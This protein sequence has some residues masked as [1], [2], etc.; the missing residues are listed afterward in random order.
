MNE[1]AAPAS[2][3]A[4]RRVSL[5]ILAQLALWTVW[6]G[7][8]LARRGHFMYDEAYGYHRAVRVAQEHWLPVTGWPW[9]GGAVAYNPGGFFDLAVAVPFLFGSDPALATWWL[10]LLSALAIGVLDLALRRGAAPPALRLAVATGLCWSY[11]HARGV[12][13]L[14][15]PNLMWTWS[16]VGL[17]L[18]LRI[19]QAGPTRLRALGLGLWMAVGLQC[20]PGAVMAIAVIGL[21]L[22]RR[23]DLRA[24]GP[25]ALVAAGFTLPFVPYLVLEAGQGF[26]NTARLLAVHSPTR[27]AWVVVVKA[28]LAPLLSVSQLAGFGTS[29]GGVWASLSGQPDRWL[30][31]AGGGLLLGYGLLQPGPLR[32]PLLAAMA[33]IP[34]LFLLT[35]R[36]YEEHFVAALVPYFVVMAAIG[37]AALWRR[38]GRARRALAAYAL[39]FVGVGVFR[40]AWEYEHRRDPT[41]PSETRRVAQWVEA[42]AGVVP[43]PADSRARHD[44]FVLWSL[45]QHLAG[46]TPVFAL[47]DREGVCRVAIS[48]DPPPSARGIAN[49]SFFLC[50]PR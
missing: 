1:P 25:A 35:R 40:T 20:H 38:G 2:D 27:F 29:T 3:A 6:A 31:L 4:H 43:V 39:F 19:L 7:A 11:W 50:E 10:V 21:V 34:A 36:W 13:R 23:R 14:W 48:A 46:R 18:A 26:E 24:P 17:A 22:V 49:D 9:M 47:A 45:A 32:A 8:L 37:A 16:L 5:Y 15:T 30:T 12:D 28:A 41:I 33:A 42:G 44:A